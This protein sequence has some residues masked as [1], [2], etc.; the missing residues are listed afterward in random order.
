MGPSFV[1]KSYNKERKKK[2]QTNK[3]RNKQKNH[4]QQKQ[5]Q[6]TA[7]TKI[8]LQPIGIEV[9]INPSTHPSNQQ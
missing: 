2:Q 6:Q 7:R 1:E 4:T 9:V 3:L 5:Q 8:H